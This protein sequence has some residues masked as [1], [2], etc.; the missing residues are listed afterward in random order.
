MVTH[1][2][3]VQEYDHEKHLQS[4]QKLNF[5]NDDDDWFLNFLVILF[6]AF[7]TRIF[8]RWL[9]FAVV[10]ILPNGYSI[11]L[12]KNKIFFKKINS[13]IKQHQN[14]CSVMNDDDD[15]DDCSFSIQR[16]K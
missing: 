12:K 16:K 10:V 13:S 6:V 7:E 11:E 15:D 4:T 8:D 14:K 3:P 9:F 1:R 5:N 2:P